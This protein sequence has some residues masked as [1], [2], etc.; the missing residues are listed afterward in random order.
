LNGIGIFALSLASALA[1]ITTIFSAAALIIIPYFFL[2]LALLVI[3]GFALREVADKIDGYDNHIIAGFAAGIIFGIVIIAVF[4]VPQYQLAQ[5]PNQL[6]VSYP[7]VNT[8]ATFNISKYPS[9]SAV[10]YTTYNSTI[11]STLNCTSFSAGFNVTINGEG[12]G[13]YNTTNC[14]LPQQNNALDTCNIAQNK[15]ISCQSYNGTNVWNGKI[16][17]VKKR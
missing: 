2:S 17:N 11:I 12:K 15:T 5:Y 1:A 7:T 16:L 8:T 9:Q 10:N 13:Y 4:L 14:Y 6:Q 3:F